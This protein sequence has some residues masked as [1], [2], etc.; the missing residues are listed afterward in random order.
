MDID[1]PPVWHG[2]ECIMPA[3]VVMPTN[4]D[5]KHLV[6]TRMQDTGERYTEA[7]AALL[8]QREEPDALASDRTRSLVGQLADVQLRGVAHELLKEIPDT[9]RRAAA[10]EGLRHPSWRVRRT[11]AQLLDRVDL[12]GEALSALT[13]ALDDEH[14][15]VR[16]KVVHTLSCEHCKP[17]GC[18]P[19]VRAICE[20]AVGDQSA[21]V[22]EMVVHICTL[23]Y[24]TQQWAI[25]LVARVARHD[26]SAKLRRSAAESIGHLRAQWDSDAQR[27]QLPTDLVRK[28]DRHAGTWIAIRDG[29]IVAAGRGQGRI[30]RRE[31]RAG[32]TRYWVA[33]PDL[34]RPHIP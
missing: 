34:A 24:F 7:R 12:T 20:R 27:R 16:R 3:G 29:R 18:L 2:W 14:P 6:R 31:L 8:S 26:N 30:L 28:T 33:P 32:A 23:H 4:G 17:S 25:D 22:R 13:R 10:I 19:D 21:L 11:C 1:E 15:Q 5:F 9:E